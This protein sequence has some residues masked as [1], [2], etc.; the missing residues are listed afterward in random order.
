MTTASLKF[1]NMLWKCT[2]RRQTVSCICNLSDNCERSVW[3]GLF[4][5]PVS[6]TCNIGHVNY[7]LQFIQYSTTYNIQTSTQYNTINSNTKCKDQLTVQSVTTSRY[8]CIYIYKM[9]KNS[10]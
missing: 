4:V 3:F 7:R 5:H 8:M 1:R 10:N 2:G 6:H 9:V